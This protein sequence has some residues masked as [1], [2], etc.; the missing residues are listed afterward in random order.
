MQPA[1]DHPSTVQWRPNAAPTAA[2]FLQAA[3]LSAVIAVVLQS[4]VNLVADTPVIF[5]HL[6]SFLIA[7]PLVWK[8][9][10]GV[11]PGRVRSEVFSS[12]TFGLN[13]IEGQ[14]RSN[15]EVVPLRVV[16]VGRYW[17]ALQLQL[18]PIDAP[19]DSLFGAGMHKTA[20]ITIW[21]STVGQNKFRMFALLAIWHAR[22]HA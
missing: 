2:C 6:G 15:G 16:E 18:R 8:W 11:H 4:L 22:R 3:L 9:Q 10:I 1:V 12:V 20:A 14:L 13:A 17:G 7:L 5:L 21:K 19:K